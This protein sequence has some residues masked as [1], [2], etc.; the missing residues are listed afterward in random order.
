[1]GLEQEEQLQ[2]EPGVPLAWD[3]TPGSLASDLV[4]AGGCRYCPS[5]EGSAPQCLA[6]ANYRAVAKPGYKRVDE[7]AQGPGRALLKW[8]GVPNWPLRGWC[9]PGT[10]RHISVHTWLY[11]LTIF[12]PHTV[13]QTHCGWGWGEDNPEGASERKAGALFTQ[14][15]WKGPQGPGEQP[16]HTGH[17]HS[18]H[19]RQECCHT[20]SPLPHTFRH[21]C[22][23]HCKAIHTLHRRQAHSGM[24]HHLTYSVEGLTGTPS[25]TCT[26]GDTR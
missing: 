6:Q 18:L 1:M 13:N 24:S 7:P 12:Q 19:R 20:P 11:N 10:L 4:R 3:L 17:L 15:K 14:L 26:Q 2:A 9:W 22:S 21:A 8:P 23:T 5:P 25:H 16:R